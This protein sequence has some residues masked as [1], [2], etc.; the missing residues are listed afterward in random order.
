MEKKIVVITINLKYILKN[1]NKTN[2][3]AEAL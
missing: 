1:L 2:A 3:K